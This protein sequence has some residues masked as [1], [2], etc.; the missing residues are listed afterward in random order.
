MEGSASP[1]KP[2][3]LIKNK[4]FSFFILLVAC[5]VKQ[6][7]ASTLSIP[8]PSSFTLIS[9]LPAS[10]KLI[11]IEFAPASIEFSTNSLTTEEHLSTTSPAAILFVKASSITLI[12]PIT[13]SLPQFN[14]LTY[15]YILLIFLVIHKHYLLHLYVLYFLQHIYLH[16]IFL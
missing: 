12:W 14:Y 15:F 8:F 1:L 2:K 11:S 5:G 6:S 4:S 16:L 10:I 9:F 7:L 3:V 13:S